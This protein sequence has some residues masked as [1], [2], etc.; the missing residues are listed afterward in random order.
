MYAGPI[1]RQINYHDAW[2]ERVHDVVFGHSHAPVSARSSAAAPR[3]GEGGHS[4]LSVSRISGDISM[5]AGSVAPTLSTTLPAASASLDD[6]SVWRRR[7]METAALRRG[8]P[9]PAAAGGHAAAAV[10]LDSSASSAASGKMSV[11]V[12]TQTPPKRRASQQTSRSPS[13]QTNKASVGTQHTPPEA[14]AAEAGKGEGSDVFAS[15]GDSL[16]L[17]SVAS[18]RSSTPISQRQPEPPSIVFTQG[19]PLPIAAVLPSNSISGEKSTSPPPSP[20]S[21]TVLKS[22]RSGQASELQPRPQPQ[23]QPQ[24]QASQ[25]EE[26][27]LS[28]QT[29]ALVSRTVSASSAQAAAEGPIRSASVL[30]KDSP[31]RPSAANHTSR[32]SSL[33]ASPIVPARAGSVP[34]ALRRSG[35]GSFISST[36]SS[37]GAHRDPYAIATDGAFDRSVGAPFGMQGQRVTGEEPAPPRPMQRPSRSGSQADSARSLSQFPPAQPQ[38]ARDSRNPS[39]GHQPPAAIPRSFSSSVA[40]EGCLPT[41]PYPFDEEPS[42]ADDSRRFAEAHRTP[43][44]AH[45][46]GSYALLHRSAAKEGADPIIRPPARVEPPTLNKH[47]PS[48]SPAPKASGFEKGGT[49]ASAR[50]S[51]Y[52]RPLPAGP[53]A[54]PRSQAAPEGSGHGRTPKRKMLSCRDMLSLPGGR[55][56]Q[57][58]GNVHASPSGL[59]VSGAVR[60]GKAA[61]AEG[62]WDDTQFRGDTVESRSDQRVRGALVGGAVRGEALAT[63][64]G[65]LYLSPSRTVTLDNINSILPYFYRIPGKAALGPDRT[66]SVAFVTADGSFLSRAGVKHDAHRQVRATAVDARAAVDERRGFVPEGCARRRTSSSSSSSSSS[67]A[68]SVDARQWR[69]AAATPATRADTETEGQSVAA[70]ARRVAYGGEGARRGD[71]RGAGVG[72]RTKTHPSA[73]PRVHDEAS[74]PSPS[75]AVGVAARGVGRGV[76]REA[77]ATPEPSPPP[78]HRALSPAERVRVDND[79]WWRDYYQHYGARCDVAGAAVRAAVAGRSPPMAAAPANA[80]GGGGGGRAA[81]REPSDDRPSEE[82]ARAARRSLQKSSA[83]QPSE[84]VLNG[85]AAQRSRALALLASGGA[86]VSPNPRL[87]DAASKGRFVVEEEQPRRKSSPWSEHSRSPPSRS[88]SMGPKGPPTASPPAAASLRRSA[89]ASRRRRSMSVDALEVEVSDD[90]DGSTVSSHGRT[91]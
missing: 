35:L 12:G 54:A 7:I 50:G 13:A 20:S 23:P 49:A 19:S 47:R 65:E 59:N 4:S 72:V 3:G 70:H 8:R 91:W 88:P 60:S 17:D 55:Q 9:L 89:S 48:T 61:G 45:G 11:T 24:P 2:R 16:A 34:E 10:V 71:G 52:A 29:L 6:P 39:Y 36:S 86:S 31:P 57:G 1:A 80:S 81:L 51:G 66:E 67:S 76:I 14:T 64:S 33:A 58:G 30:S 68:A 38:W 37:H 56:G 22:T 84:A 73:P 42:P 26:R 44:A 74:S 85:L 25:K 77:F 63:D 78:L 43:V 75:S 41:Y 18:G 32:S 53:T 90:S 40:A 5:G 28:L 15:R 82:E 21:P 79:A 87:A 27:P 62:R 46:S 83:F 69:R